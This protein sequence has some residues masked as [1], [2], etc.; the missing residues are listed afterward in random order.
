MTD[1]PKMKNIRQKMSAEQRLVSK[2]KQK[3]LMAN[4]R[5]TQ[6]N[7]KLKIQQQTG[8]KI[9][10]G[11]YAIVKRNEYYIANKN[12]MSEEQLQIVKDNNHLFCIHNL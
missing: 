6:K 7:H 2:E 8:I 10:A 9:C 1:Q 4:Y 12:F 3:L 11:K 5:Q